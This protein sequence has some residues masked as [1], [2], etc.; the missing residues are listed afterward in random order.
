MNVNSP[1]SPNPVLS[2]K[3][4]GNPDASIQIAFRAPQAL[5]TFCTFLGVEGETVFTFYIL[6]FYFPY[7][8]LD[9]KPISPQGGKNQEKVPM[10][11][12]IK[13]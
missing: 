8:V 5:L 10:L 1:V 2:Q 13:S 11:Y 6:D 9:E 3:L 12:F 4:L 7:P